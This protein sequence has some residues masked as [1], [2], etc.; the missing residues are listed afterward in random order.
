MHLLNKA[1]HTYSNSNLITFAILPSGETE[2]SIINYPNRTKHEG[3]KKKTF[4]IWNRNECELPTIEENNC[5]LANEME[6]MISGCSNME[7]IVENDTMKYYDYT[8]SRQFGFYG[9]AIVI[10]SVLCSC[11]ITLWPQHN[12]I[13][14]PKY[15]YVS[16]LQ[17]I[18]GFFSI[19]SI[20]HI[21]RC[22]I[23]MNV[24]CIK[25]GK[26]FLSLFCF[27]SSTFI[28]A[29][30]LIYALWCFILGK[31]HPMPFVGYN[32]RIAAWA[33]LWISLWFQF[34]INW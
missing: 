10:V 3:T 29:Y 25:R 5:Y 17:A 22:S 23:I 16:I 26:S 30:L 6:E 11:L 13:E 18:V 24:D 20:L 31:R 21:F 8:I 15:W 4:S 9:F 27:S 14:M 7:T 32:C 33:T 28:V 1:R 19:V 34:P 2:D 12:V